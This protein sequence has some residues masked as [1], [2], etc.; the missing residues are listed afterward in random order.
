MKQQHT[1]L[2]T[3]VKMAKIWYLF[4]GFVHRHEYDTLIL[5]FSDHGFIIFQFPDKH[6]VRTV[7]SFLSY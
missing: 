3:K 1:I 5:I 6:M 4:P 2:V 7:S